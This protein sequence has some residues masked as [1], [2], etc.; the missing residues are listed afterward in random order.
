MD[1]EAYIMRISGASPVQL[2]VISFELMVQFLSESIACAD[3]ED[4]ENFRANLQKAKNTLEQLIQSLDFSVP[5]SQEFHDIYRYSYKL[6]SDVHFS[7]DMKAACAAVK[8]VLELM[9]ML[10]E[11]WRETAEKHDTTESDAPK[12]Y[13]GLTYGRDGQANEYIEENT[14]R[15]YMA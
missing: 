10:L 14:D 1:N 11:G 5:L 13:T 6:L 15:G 4:K 2:V 9:Q 8:E 3:A 12:V 7:S